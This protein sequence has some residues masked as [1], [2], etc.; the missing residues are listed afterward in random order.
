MIYTVTDWT[1]KGEQPAQTFAFRH[2]AVAA[3]AKCDNGTTECSGWGPAHFVRSG[4]H[5]PAH[6]G[7]WSPWR[8]AP[9]DAVHP[10]A[11]AFAA[12]VNCAQGN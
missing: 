2:Y 3:A 1:S 12:Q 9:R 10:D 6:A 4:Y 7:T 8:G 11:A 5:G